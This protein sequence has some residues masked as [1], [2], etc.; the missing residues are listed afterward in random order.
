[1]QRLCGEEGRLPK[2]RLIGICV[3]ALMCGL[4]PRV[5]LSA[6][7]TVYGGL[8]T[9]EN[10]ALSPDGLHIAYVR[11]DGDTRVVLVATV[12]DQKLV[13]FARV[14]EEK[15]RT[16]EWADNDN[17]LIGTSVTSAV[18]GFRIEAFLVTV[19]NVEKNQTRQLP[20]QVP[21]I[22]EHFS[23][24]VF[25]WPQIRHVD[26][27][28]LVFTRTA[29]THEGSA[30]VRC[31]LTSGLNRLA[32][33][34]HDVSWLMDAQG[35]LAGQRDYDP[36][37]QRWSISGFR[38][39]TCMSSRRVTPGWIILRSLDSD[40]RQRRCSWNRSKMEKHCGSSCRLLMEN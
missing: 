35:Q 6:P 21:G 22:D 20:G 13:H 4:I 19:Y 14:G 18:V 17:I 9:I 5:G 28:T 10:V 36:Q 37:T 32:R 27:H 30:L 15:L 2:I 39:T 16:I 26:G 23:N 3:L 1:M 31:D 24:I 34:G 38:E 11:T 33:L 7:L 29:D 40:P 25:G 8:P 12:A